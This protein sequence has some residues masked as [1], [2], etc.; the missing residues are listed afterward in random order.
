MAVLHR[1]AECKGPVRE[2][3]AHRTKRHYARVICQSC[4]GLFIHSGIDTTT[5]QQDASDIMIRV[6]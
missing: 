6:I 5:K 1:C 3:Q 2:W 4:E